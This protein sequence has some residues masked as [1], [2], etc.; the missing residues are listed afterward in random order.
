MDWW[1]ALGKV[2]CGV[3]ATSPTHWLRICGVAAI[4]RVDSVRAAMQY[5]PPIER[6]HLAR[7]PGRRALYGARINAAH[8]WLAVLVHATT[9][10]ERVKR[11]P[12]VRSPAPSVR[13]T[14]RNL[15]ALRALLRLHGKLGT[16][17]YLTVPLSCES[18]KTATSTS[19]TNIIATVYH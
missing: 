5:S 15:R 11:R 7:S 17:H 8:I 19:S 2:T 4:L 9:E 13:K 18:G 12:L 16:L 1:L 3:V 14:E 6:P 10:T